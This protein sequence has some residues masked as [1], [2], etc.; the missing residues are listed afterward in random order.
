[1]NA[2]RRQSLLQQAIAE[3]LLHPN[4]VW[5]EPERESRPWAVALMT[6]LGA[7]L[8]AVPLLGLIGLMLWEVTRSNG[9]LFVVGALIMVLATALLRQPVQTLFLEQLAVPMLL[10]GGMAMGVAAFID[11]PLQGAAALQGLVTLLVAAYLPQAWLRALLGAIAVPLAVLALQPDD[12]LRFSY[13]HGNGYVSYWLALHV[14]LMGWMAVLGLQRRLLE[15]PERARGA[16]VLEPLFAGGLLATLCGLALWSGMTMFLGAHLSGWGWSRLAEVARPLTALSELS[17]LLALVA[18]ARLAWA[19]PRLRRP[20]CLGVALVPVTLAWW[21]PSLGAVLLALAWCAS[22]HRW[23]LAVVAA[24]AAA[25]IVGS[26]YYRLDWPLAHKAG[27]LAGAGVLLAGLSRWGARGLP[28]AVEAAPRPADVAAVPA[29]RWHA[30]VAPAG[31]ALSALA[32]LAM[33]NVG[34]WQQEKLIAEGQTV[35]V[36]LQPRDPRSLLQGD[37]MALNLAVALESLPGLNDALG[38]DRPVVVA[39]RDERGIATLQRLDE[40]QPLA[41]GELRIQLTPKNGRWVIVTD[42]WFFKEGE[43]QRWAPARYGEFRV[44]ARGKAVLVGL[45]DMALKPL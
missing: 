32:T 17:T 40:G 31:I 30:R 39:R 10:G 16:V 45:R 20:W 38:S 42:A 33:V 14:V 35:L 9:A 36:E 19:W 29:P 4:A 13:D 7:W 28:A 37:Y 11:L 27:L 43:A 3:G 25:W 15:S 21:L 1:M 24:L 8:A 44:D 22:S 2:A 23:R 41:P 26:F 6:A 18:A 5:P 34:I 12:V